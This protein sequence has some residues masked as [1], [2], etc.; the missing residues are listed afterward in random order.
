MA[1]LAEIDEKNVGKIVITDAEWRFKELLSSIPSSKFKADNGLNGSWRFSLTW[2]TCLALKGTLKQNLEVGPKLAAWMEDL[3]NNVI[4]PAYALRTQ[5]TG[6][7]YDFLFPHQ[8]GDVAFLTTIKRGILANGTGSG[9]AQPLS[10]PILTPDGWKTMGEI[11]VGDFVIGSDGLPTRVW[12]TNPQGVRDVYKVTLKDGSFTYCDLNHLWDVRSKK[13]DVADMHRILTTRD[14]IKYGVKSSNGNLKFKLPTVRPVEFPKKSLGISPYIMGAIL[15][16]GSMRANAVTFTS[17]D[18]EITERINNEL[19]DGVVLKCIGQSEIQFMFHN[20]NRVDT[21]KAGKRPTNPVFSVMDSYGLIGTG[22]STKFIPKDYLFS[23]AEDRLACLQG[24]MDTDGTTSNNVHSFCTVSLQLAY[25]VRELV[26]SLG[27]TAVWSYHKR[28]ELGNYDPIV[29]T[30]RLP[31]HLN[32]FHLSR[33]ATLV[34]TKDKYKLSRFIE[35]IEFSHKEESKCIAIESE[36]RLYVTRDYILTHNS[37]SG[38]STIRRLHELGEDVF[39]LLIACPNSTKISWEREIEKVWPGLTIHVVDG[40][41]AKRRKM[42]ET[43]AHVVIINWESIRAHSR[44]KPFGSIALKKCQKCGGLGD[45]KETACEAHPKELNKIEFKSVIGDEI[46]RIA[47]PASKASRSFKSA[48]GDAEFRFG[49]SGTPIGGSPENLF[50]PLNWLSPES[51]P[52]KV[53][54]IDRFCITSDN[55]WGGKIVLGLRPEMEEEFFSGLDPYLRRMPNEI[56]LPFLPPIIRSRR[57]VEMGT[58]QAR[59]YKQMKEQMLSEIDNGDVIF[60]TSPLTKLTRLLQF[61]TSYAD[62]EY[63]DVYDDVTGLTTEKQFVKLTDPSA[64]LDA[65]MEDLPDFGDDSCIIFAVSSQLIKMLSARMTKLN[66][67]HGLIIGD[68][69]S[70]TRQMHMDAFQAGEIQFILVTIAAGGTGITLTQ[71]NT[72]IFLQRSWSLIENIQAEGRGR[73]I[74]SEKYD[75]IKIID[76]VTKNTQQEKVFEAIDAKSDQLEVILRDKDLVRKFIT[77]ELDMSLDDMM[78]KKEDEEE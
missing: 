13:D 32:P 64:T 69:D 54:F 1:L 76:Y 18:S 62:V 20:L 77:N 73:R 52:S 27:G 39:P 36:D 22:S 31:D 41:L 9:K 65:L 30:I 72:M 56:I 33:K 48:T 66:I 37:I 17:Q 3:Y 24:L 21:I 45:V 46:H 16:D 74:G 5:I 10:E 75:H 50:S 34:T 26:Q 7:G 61:A 71:A 8:K 12:A 15:G 29:I 63:R 28:P 57:D 60:T 53:K 38:M 2:Q 58:K 4:A 68:Q 70:K 6:P 55:P 67:R 11:E 23:S 44:L 14:L 47:D 40:S 59:A 25:D 49:L 78:P 43:P 42:L 35:S 19:I 51:Y